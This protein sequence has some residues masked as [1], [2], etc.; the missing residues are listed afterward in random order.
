M[1]NLKAVHYA[2]FSRKSVL[3]AAIGLAIVSG[4]I[5]LFFCSSQL[6]NRRIEVLSRYESNVSAWLDGA[7]QAV[8]I[9]DTDMKKL[10]LRV[11]DSETY[12]LFAGD[13][14]DVDQRITGSINNTEHGFEYSGNMAVLAAE[15]PAIRR[16]L[17]EFM[18]YNGLLDARLINKEGQ[19]LLSALST[20]VPLA[21]AQSRAALQAMETGKTVFLPVRGGVNGLVLDVFEPVYDL[22]E[23]DKCVAAF[24]TSASVLSRVTQFV[25]RPKHNDMALAFMVQQNGGTW[26]KMQVTEPLR[27]SENLERQF[28]NAHGNLPFGLRESV[29]PGGGMVYSMSLFIPGLNWSLVQET[30]ASVMDRLI[31]RAELPVYVTGILGWVIFMLLCILLW[32]IGFGRQQRAVASELRRLHLMASRQKEL[33]DRMNSSLDIGMFLTDVKG[34]IHICNPA[35]ANILGKDEKDISEQFL[36]SCFPTETAS[37]LL[38]RVRQAAINNKSDGCEISLEHDGEKHL[39]RVMIFPFLDAGEEHVRSSIRGAVVTMKDITE[40][41]RRSERMQQ[42]QRSLIEAF[43]RAEE[44]VDPYLVGHSHRMARLGELLADSMGLSED[45]KSTVVMGAQLSQIGKLFIPRELLT[46]RGGLTQME[47]A[48]IHKAPEHAF[49]LM[50]GID[51][52]LPVA[53]ALYEMYEH[54]DGSGYPRGLKGEEILSEARIL[55]VLNAFCAMVRSRSYR[56]GM[57]D[58]MALKELTDNPHY[59]QFVVDHLRRVLNTPEG[60][61]AVHHADI[62]ASNA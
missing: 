38:D 16:I 59:D 17:L 33:L 57:T 62:Q 20:P 3:L 2:G 27:L 29:S 19:T 7:V 30:P 24:M 15:V 13:L 55:N 36:F 6:E 51:F 40:F 47:L 43:I 52:D 39:Y 35:F 61:H 4:A 44:S 42:Q 25:A 34:Q 37:E 60:L 9:W 28:E 22:E 32:W 50:D 21:S 46:K 48:E 58:E 10:R 18:N 56:E 31:F 45:V 54:V 11:S 12:R 5:T 49:R 8:S 26:E 14:Y 41:R 1:N 23:P 53:R